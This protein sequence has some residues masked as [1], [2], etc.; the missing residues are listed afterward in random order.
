MNV[1]YVYLTDT[2][3]TNSYAQSYL[4]KCNPNEITVIY[5]YYQHQGRGQIGRYW[6]SD[7]DKNFSLSIIYFPKQLG[8]ANSFQIIR[9]S[10]LAIN[11]A[12]KEVFGIKCQI[13]W[14]N[15]IYYNHKKL[16]GILIQNTISGKNIKNAII[17]IGLNVNSVDF[18]EDLPNPISLKQITRTHYDLKSSMLF[19][20]NKVCELL[21]N[22]QF[23]HELYHN[24]LYKI[25]QKQRFELEPGNSFLAT[26][27]GTDNN[28]LILLEKEDGSIEKYNFH[29]IR[30]IIDNTEPV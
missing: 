17:G 30:F 24:N 20:V 26:I 3:S 25:G 13:K 19:F 8:A 9:D 14:P 18:P 29:E 1:K 16:G 7:R 5:T 21:F 27:L 28:G 22:N 12:I 10:S 6:F 2:A 23:D 4:S 11:M 15:D